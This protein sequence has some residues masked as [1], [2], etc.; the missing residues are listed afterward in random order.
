MKLYYGVYTMRVILWLP[1]TNTSFHNVVF[2]FKGETEQREHL[3]D[4]TDS[5]KIAA[6]AARKKALESKKERR[7]EGA[8]VQRGAEAEAAWRFLGGDANKVG[9][10][11]PAMLHS[12]MTRVLSISM[13]F[14]VWRDV[15]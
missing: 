1:S 6:N 11:R 15:E 3:R 14:S 4:C 10:V 8:E 13:R 5:K 12:N 7:E 2:V 9:G